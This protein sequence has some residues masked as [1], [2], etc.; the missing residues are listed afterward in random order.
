MN[1]AGPGTADD[2][3]ARVTSRYLTSNA[4]TL[5]WMLERP[6]LHGR[7]L[8]TKLN[9]LTLLDYGPSDGM[10]GPDWLYGWIQGRGLEAVTT[11]ARRYEETDPDFAARLDEAGRSL[12][13]ALDE[14]WS[15]DG[16]GYFCY[17]RD[18]RPVYPTNDGVAPQTLCGDV[19]TYS[20]AFFAKGLICGAARYAPDDVPRHLR[21]LAKVIEAIDDDRFQMAEKV[22]LDPA[23]AHAEPADF[24]PRMI[25]LGAAGMLARLGLGGETKYA[26]RFIGHIL[27]RHHDPATSLLRNVPGEDD[28]NVGHGIEFVGFALDHLP[29]DADPET[30]ARLEAILVAS[31]DMG[32][33]GPGIRLTVSAGTGRPVSPYCPWW[34]LPE[35][36]RSAA[37]AHARSGSAD[38]L[39]LWQ[40]ADRT[41]FKDY[42]RGTPPIAVQCLTPDGPIDYVPATPCLD[43]GYHTGLSLLAAADVAERLASRTTKAN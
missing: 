30:V 35:T 5:N 21:S 43:P 28:C 8:N 27:D 41:F 40:K 7:F 20:D 6:R 23:T 18:L 33:Q 12:Y 14:L 15:R 25:L 42:W 37:L 26:D 31:F 3:L 10:R 24:G 17:D 19:Y 32:F 22:A 29:P 39:R 9:P 34:S 38:T 16:H 4:A 2:F 36:I 13:T 1:D 11:H